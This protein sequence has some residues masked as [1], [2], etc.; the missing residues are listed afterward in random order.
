MASIIQY[1]NV[2]LVLSFKVIKDDTNIQLIKLIMQ[3]QPC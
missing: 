2:F 3:V 1:L